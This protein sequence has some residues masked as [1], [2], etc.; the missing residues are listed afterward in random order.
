MT[1]YNN[2]LGTDS[3][4]SA[5]IWISDRSGHIGLFKTATG[6]LVPGT[7]H[8]TE[9]SL[10]DIAFIGSQMYGT[11]FEELGSINDKTGSFKPIGAYPDGIEMN[12]LVGDGSDLLGAAYNSD[13]IY[14]ITVG[15]H[16]TISD[17]KSV[18]LR[19]AGDLT[20]SGNTLYKLVIEGSGLGVDYLYNVTAGKL[21]GEFK[22]SSGTH[23][24][25][26]YGL[27]DSG[28]A[29]YG[30][31]GNDIYRVNLATA[32][33]TFLSSDAA[34]GIGKASGAAS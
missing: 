27:V 29:M 21:V 11:T 10:T 14:K 12:A 24:N 17:Y 3:G 19:S 18:G 22:T 32:R 6:A 34:S 8:D 20:W 5:E 15:S 23:F 2:P 33:L 9:A 26:L 25:D 1:Y 16:P 30:V 4:S 13:E 31:A 28:G 7:M